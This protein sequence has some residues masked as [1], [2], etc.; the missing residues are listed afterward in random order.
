MSA[1]ILAQSVNIHFSDVLQLSS[2]MEHMEFHEATYGDDIFSF[3]SKHY[4]KDLEA[5][6]KDSKEDS[7]HKNLPFNHRIACDT[8]Q[9]CIVNWDQGSLV[10]NKSSLAQ[11]DDFFYYNF[12]TYL[13]NTDIFQPP[14]LA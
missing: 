8:L 11:N 1:F 7:D 4:G 10:P 9:F 14:R 13:K 3:I 12:Y 2:L 5:H 6:K